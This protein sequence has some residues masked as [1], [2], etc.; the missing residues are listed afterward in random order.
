MA[1]VADHSGKST[2]IKT[3]L[4][5]RGY[6]IMREHYDC[7]TA[8]E[9]RQYHAWTLMTVSLHMR[10]DNIMHGHY[11][12]CQLHMCACLAKHEDLLHI[13]HPQ[14]HSTLHHGNRNHNAHTPGC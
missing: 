2:D 5:M 14:Y 3:S 6:N 13:L 12:M 11:R 9:R 4:R 1:A 8:H 10:G 7:V